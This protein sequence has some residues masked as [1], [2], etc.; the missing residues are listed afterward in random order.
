VHQ[1]DG[2]SRTH[3]IALER[4]IG[5]VGQLES[6]VDAIGGNVLDSFVE[7]SDVDAK[8]LG[9]L[10]QVAGADAVD[11]VLVLLDLLEGDV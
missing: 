9:Y 5:A 7:E 10:V 2:L 6:D 8:G 4:R 11:A 3:G 1:F